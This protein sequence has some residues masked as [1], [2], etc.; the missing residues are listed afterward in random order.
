VKKLLKIIRTEFFMVL[1][2]F[3]QPACPNCPAAKKLVK[4]LKIKNLKLKIEVYDTSSV[5]GMAEGA[6]YR[7]MSTPTLLLC[8]DEGK[9][10]EEWRGKTPKEK[11][12]LS[13]LKV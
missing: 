1:K 5:D 3:T 2:V 6:F 11:E 10:L 7:V 9:M 4:E 13:K 12:I 8:D